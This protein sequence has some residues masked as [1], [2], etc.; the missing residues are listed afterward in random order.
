M[1]Q[2]HFADLDMEMVPWD[3]FI[4]AFQIHTNQKVDLHDEILLKHVLDN[5]N[6]GVVTPKEFNS[7]LKCFGPIGKT[8]INVWIRLFNTL[9]SIVNFVL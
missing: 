6:L 4:A 7:F 9:I 2:S 1:W 3:R 8:M 5:D